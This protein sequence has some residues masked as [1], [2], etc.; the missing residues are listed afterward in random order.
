MNNYT[1]ERCSAVFSSGD[2]Y[3]HL[4][5]SMH[6]NPSYPVRKEDPLPKG[7]K[8]CT[9]LQCKLCY[10]EL[11]ETGEQDDLSDINTTEV[12]AVMKVPNTRVTRGDGQV[13][14][15]AQAPPKLRKSSHCHQTKHQASSSESEPSSEDESFD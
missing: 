9:G 8:L 7:V 11:Q 3:R 14:S 5:T 6:F 12:P 13:R 15:P 10:E 4:K 2:I 1:G